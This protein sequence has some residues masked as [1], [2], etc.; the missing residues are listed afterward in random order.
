MCEILTAETYEKL[1]EYVYL[2]INVVIITIHSPNKSA[3]PRLGALTRF[4]AV[5]TSISNHKNV[6]IING[7]TMVLSSQ[8]AQ[9]DKTRLK[10][11]E[12]GKKP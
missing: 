11:D 10:R 3:N 6:M 2:L 4:G 5:T 12:E 1:K 7:E 9:G 8:I